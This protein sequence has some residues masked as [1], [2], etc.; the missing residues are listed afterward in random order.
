MSL[1]SEPE[2]VNVWGAQKSIPLA[3]CSLTKWI[4]LNSIPRP[5]KR[6]Q[7]RALLNL[8]WLSPIPPAYVAWWNRFPW[9]ELLGSLKVYKF[10]IFITF[11]FINENCKEVLNIRTKFTGISLMNVVCHRLY[12]IV[13]TVALLWRWFW[14]Y[15]SHTSQLLQHPKSPPHTHCNHRQHL[16]HSTSPQPPPPTRGQIQSPWLGDKV[17]SGTGLRSTLA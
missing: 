16:I 11:C 6:L 5:L 15:S 12:D 4:P 14:L 1:S 13:A 3:F 17:D 2:F 9:I 7:I 8:R 10:A